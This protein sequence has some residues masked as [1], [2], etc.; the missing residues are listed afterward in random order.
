MSCQ[1]KAQIER[2]SLLVKLSM[3]LVQGKITEIL[4]TYG[5]EQTAV[6]LNYSGKTLLKNAPQGVFTGGFFSS[7]F[8]YRVSVLAHK[9]PEVSFLLPSKERGY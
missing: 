1:L 2:S 4:S 5:K 8:I 9:Y 3:E 6:Y 7:S